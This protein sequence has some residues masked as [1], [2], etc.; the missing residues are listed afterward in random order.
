MKY[1][2]HWCRNVQTK[3]GEDRVEIL[4]E[5]AILNEYFY[6]WYDKVV[7]KYGI[8]GAK[9]LFPT[10]DDLTKACTDDW[11][12]LHWAWEYVGMD[13]GTLQEVLT[14]HKNRD[15]IVCVFLDDSDDKYSTGKEY[16]I[17]AAFPCIDGVTLYLEE[18]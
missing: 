7:A 5:Q 16:Y 1:M 6:H 2:K 13:V 9:D 11:V 18:I 17:D 3:A 15:K 10:F 8:E 14:K 4:S 12:G